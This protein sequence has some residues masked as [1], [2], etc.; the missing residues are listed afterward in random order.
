MEKL[1]TQ[2]IIKAARSKK[3]I[4][5]E[6]QK[7]SFFPEIGPITEAKRREWKVINK[8]SLQEGREANVLYP[9]IRSSIKMLKAVLKKS[10]EGAKGS[11]KE[12]A[13]DSCPENALHII[14]TSGYSAD[15]PIG[16]QPVPED[17][18]KLNLTKGVSMSLPSSPLLP[19]QSYLMQTRSNKKSPGPIRKPKYVESP[20]LPG[21]AVV[22]PSR[23][24]SEPTEPNQN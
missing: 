1:K 6:G 21:D 5:F 22:V 14:A 3:D 2:R 15:S 11:K 19:R 8:D 10:R 13:G 23:K 16:N 9:A 17:M 7:I 18:Y 20:R 12:S 4:S 24:V